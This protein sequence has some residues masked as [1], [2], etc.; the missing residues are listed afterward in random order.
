MDGIGGKDPSQEDLKV[1]KSLRDIIDHTLRNGGEILVHHCFDGVDSTNG[2][3]YAYNI[4]PY[5]DILGFLDTPSI[6]TNRY[7]RGA[8]LTLPEGIPE[9]ELEELK[10]LSKDTDIMWA[11][12]K[13]RRHFLTGGVLENCILGFMVYFRATLINM[14]PCFCIDELCV[15]L[16]KIEGEK[17]KKIFTDRGVRIVSYQEAMQMLGTH[18]GSKA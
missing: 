7:G 12:R 10:H 9:R 11:T 2:T 16:D 18:I 13:R 14:A 4:Y 6:L 17:T 8:P 5:L 1:H 3:F 15:S